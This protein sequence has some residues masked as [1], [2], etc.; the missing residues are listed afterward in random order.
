LPYS[1]CGSGNLKIKFIPSTSHCKINQYLKVDG[2]AAA[3]GCQLVAMCDI[4]VASTNA[5]FS[6]PGVNLGLFCSTPGVA[7]ARS[8]PMK[9]ASYMLYTG[10]P[11][12]AEEAFKAGLVSRVV[13][14][15]NLG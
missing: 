13:A 2:I 3:A 11:I 4:V 7:V 9:L 10:L 8:I 5:T 12:T 15:E 14:A 6:T 1:N